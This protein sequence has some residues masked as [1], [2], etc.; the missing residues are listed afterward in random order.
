VFGAK[1]NREF[2]RVAQDST[3]PIFSTWNG[4][5]ARYNV[6][7]STITVKRILVDEVAQPNTDFDNLRKLHNP[8]PVMAEQIA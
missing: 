8:T 5:R 6:V 2:G 1:R 7:Q 3:P 4:E